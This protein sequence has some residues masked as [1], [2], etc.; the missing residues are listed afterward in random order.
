[1]TKWRTRTRARG[2]SCYVLRVGY[3]V[4]CAACCVLRGGG[5]ESASVWVAIEPPLPRVPSLSSPCLS[6]L[7]PSPIPSLARLF[8][9]PLASESTRDTQARRS[10]CERAHTRCDFLSSPFFSSFMA[11][12]EK[13]KGTWALGWAHLRRCGGWDN[14]MH[15]V[16][17]LVLFWFFASPVS[18]PVSFGGAGKRSV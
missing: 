6:S 4:L 2:E 15:I 5:E 14:E 1:M 10:R 7:T 16:L 9:P 12:C 17:F 3:Y 18:S 8:G 13:A 11:F